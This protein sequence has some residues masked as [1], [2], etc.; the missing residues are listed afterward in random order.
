MR[1]FKFVIRAPAGETARNFSQVAFAGMSTA[2]EL[3]RYTL[4][5]ERNEAKVNC[6][7]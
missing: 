5:E 7:K 6:E 1:K 3:Y 2:S 4:S